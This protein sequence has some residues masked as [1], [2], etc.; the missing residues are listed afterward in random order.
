MEPLPRPLSRGIR[1]PGGEREAP[2]ASRRSCRS[3]SLVPPSRDHPFRKPP[4]VSIS[5]CA[6]T[7]PCPPAGNNGVRPRIHRCKLRSSGEIRI[8]VS[9]VLLDGY[10]IRRRVPRKDRRYYSP[11]LKDIL[12][13]TV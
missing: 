13:F 10:K 7:S 6:F 3:A 9:P 8:P 12:R 2:P 1:R 11:R 4:T 5:T